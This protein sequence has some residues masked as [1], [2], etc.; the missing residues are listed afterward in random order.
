VESQHV[1]RRA[2][3]IRRDL[4][5]ERIAIDRYR[6]SIR[7]LDGEDTVTRRLIDSILAVKERHADEL[8]NLLLQGPV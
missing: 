8:A 6:E 1:L 4:V 5:N 3:T 2:D 7:F